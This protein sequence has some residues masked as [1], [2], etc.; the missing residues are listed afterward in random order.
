[1]ALLCLG[2]KDLVQQVSSPRDWKT[3]VFWLHGAP[4]IGKSRLARDITHAHAVSQD[5]IYSKCGG[6]K[7]WDG[8]NGQSCVIWD[9][10]EAEYPW[11]NLLQLLD[12]Y[13]MKVEVKGSS[14]EMVAKLIII[15]SNFSPENLFGTK[16]NFL[17]LKR[18]LTLI[19]N[20]TGPIYE[21]IT[22]HPEVNTE[23]TY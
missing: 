14:A 17:A 7:W 2:I 8:Y 15:T 22:M 5:D 18:R 23:H 13:P 3:A 10:I 6:T 1:M 11:N 20:F 16:L 12:R 21:D 9:E 4:G 19:L